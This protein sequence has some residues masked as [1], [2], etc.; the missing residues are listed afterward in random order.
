MSVDQAASDGDKNAVGRL[1]AWL[2]D[3]RDLR[4]RIVDSNDGIIATAGLLE[5][6]AG[7]GAS[8]TVL[9]IAAAAATLAGCLSVAGATWA[10]ESTDRD[11]Q[12]RLIEDERAQLAASPEAELA[13][14]TEYWENKGLSPD[15]AARVADELT[16]RDALAA[17]LEYEHGITEIPSAAASFRAGA[18]A[19]IAYALGAMIPLLITL[20]VPVS[21]EAWAV[22][23]A[24]I[25][26]LT[27]T[28]LVVSRTGHLPTTRVLVRTLVV[29]VGTMLISY[30]AGF[31]L[32]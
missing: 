12:L 1:R 32:F 26:S 11:A 9:I 16:A 15:V 17:Q 28:S 6:F 19:G 30:L 4:A 20:F 7:A 21:I 2:E 29:G 24:V 27:I 22:L 23:A 31:F 13:E 10:E 5:G 18:S 25:V 8:D 3:G 14:L